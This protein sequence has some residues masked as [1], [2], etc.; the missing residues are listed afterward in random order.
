MT[1]DP[2]GKTPHGGVCAY[3]VL[4]LCVFG[5]LG[6][7]VFVIEMSRRAWKRPSN[8][9]ETRNRIYIYIYINMYR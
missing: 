5:K 3:D 4:H 1:K 8:K 2:I 9:V 7:N 6:A